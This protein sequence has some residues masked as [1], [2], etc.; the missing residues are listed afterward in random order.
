MKSQKIVRTFPHN[1]TNSLGE[2]NYLL[3]KG[4]VVI[5]CHEFDVSSTQKGLEYILEKDDEVKENT[6][7]TDT[8]K[9]AISKA[10]KE[11]NTRQ[12]FIFN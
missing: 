6:I 10:I 12:P 9:Q 3:E 4:Y 5:M 8:I 7:S 1:Y 2:I 11:Q